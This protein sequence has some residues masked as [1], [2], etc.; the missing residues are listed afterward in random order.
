MR[1]RLAILD[2]GGVVPRLSHIVIS[3][4]QYHDFVF[5]NRDAVLII[6]TD[7]D[8]D[9]PVTADQIRA[10]Q[11]EL[12]AT[13]TGGNVDRLVPERPPGV[14]HRSHRPSPW[15]IGL[16][17]ADDVPGRALGLRSSASGRAGRRP[18]RRNASGPV[19]G[20]SGT[21][22][23]ISDAVHDHHERLEDAIGATPERCRSVE[24]VGRALGPTGAVTVRG[25][26]LRT[27]VGDAARRRAATAGVTGL[28]GS[29]RPSCVPGDRSPRVRLRIGYARRRRG[30]HVPTLEATGR[31]RHQCPGGQIRSNA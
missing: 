1:H 21:M 8:D 24:P 16:M 14:N 28:R 20:P 19:S 26:V 13:P 27:V 22:A 10:A 12:E 5:R 11:L 7:R 29:P 23:S 25:V 6:S 3:L 30:C 4:C 31:A 17:P 9:G 18:P 2:F 15:P